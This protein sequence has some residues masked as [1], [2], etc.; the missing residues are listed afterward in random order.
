MSDVV[1]IDDLRKRKQN[2]HP[3]R[4][5]P[6][7]RP[8][9][10][11]HKEP[12]PVSNSRTTFGDLKTAVRLREQLDAELQVATDQIILAGQTLSMLGRT[13]GASYHT[14]ILRMRDAIT[15]LA[16]AKQFAPSPHLPEPPNG[17]A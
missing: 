17:A 6:S 4:G 11:P 14:A 15:K 13:T 16:E 3:G 12:R 1:H 8:D 9:L 7:Y 2:S 5:C 10:P